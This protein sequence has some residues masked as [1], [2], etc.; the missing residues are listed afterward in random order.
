MGRVSGGVPLYLIRVLCPHRPA[1]IQYY[2]TIC[3]TRKAS[4]G[5]HA[6]G[7]APMQ[8]DNVYFWTDTIKDWKRLLKPDK[9]KEVIISSWQ[10]LTDRKM[11]RVYGFVIM[12]NHLHIVWE[13]NEPNGKEIGTPPGPTQVSTNT[14]ATQF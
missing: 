10:E 4:I 2:D 14:R 9:Y 1:A 7:S 12:P 6:E 8:F 13:M 5:I 3:N 11:I